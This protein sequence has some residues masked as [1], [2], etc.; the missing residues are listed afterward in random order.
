MTD[1]IKE[2]AMSWWLLVLWEKLSSY[3]TITTGGT[4][5]SWYPFGV[6]LTDQKLQES[7]K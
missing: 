3:L 6:I 5:S 1:S 4:Q 7:K 2:L